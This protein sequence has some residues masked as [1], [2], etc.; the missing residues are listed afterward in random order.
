[1]ALAAL[2]YGPG[3]FLLFPPPSIGG[4]PE[5]FPPNYGF[6]LP[7][8]YLVWFAVVAIAYPVCRQYAS[9]K[10]RRRDL[11]WLSYF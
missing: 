11:R 7:V 1:M 5:L 10:R 9:L 3:R 2:R 4:P 8:V 6:S